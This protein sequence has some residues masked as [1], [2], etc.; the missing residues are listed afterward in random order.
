MKRK[1][2]SLIVFYSIGIALFFMMGFLMLVIIGAGT[3]GEIA[4][5][6]SQNNESRAL[7]SYLSTCARTNDAEGG[8]S[9]AWE[10]EGPVLMI[11][12]GSSGFGLMIYQRE[13][14]LLEN[15]G[16]MDSAPDPDI[17]QVIGR[18]E[19]FRVEEPAKGTFVVI[20]DAGRV[21][22]H[23]RSERSAK[24]AGLVADETEK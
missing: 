6:Q 14:Y 22:F 16:Q 5:G 23:I 8:I 3:Y 24:T 12:D 21:M 11:A 4:R 9:V 20:T 1:G 17:A 19:E 2:F 15:Y 18:T 13:G 7:L 10:E